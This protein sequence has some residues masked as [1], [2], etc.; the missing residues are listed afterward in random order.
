MALGVATPK[1]R[2]WANCGYSISGLARTRD[3]HVRVA[4]GNEA[5]R[6]QVVPGS[7]TLEQAAGMPMIVGE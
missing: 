3:G 1:F 2:F 6:A 5:Q 7:A 4:R